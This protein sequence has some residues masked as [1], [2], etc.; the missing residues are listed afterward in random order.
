MVANWKMN[1]SIAE[2]RAFCQEF[3][4]LVNNIR[5]IDMVICPPFTSLQVLKSE[6]ESSIVK[7]GAQNL[8]G[9]ENGAYTGEISASMLTD[10][11]CCYVIIGHS[12]RRRI[13]GEDDGLIN[14]KVKAALSAG[15]IPILC[16]GETL[17][18]REKSIAEEVVEN[19][20]FSCLENISLKEGELVIAYEPVWAIGTGMNASSEDAQEMIKFIRN[21]LCRIFDKSTAES[22]RILYG[23]SVNENNI[24]E[25]MVKKDIDGA[26]IGGASLQPASFAGIVRFGQND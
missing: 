24:E 10:V 2:T 3:M 5:N 14:R 25:L 9:E 12:E 7:L 19:Q 8:F 13:M 26:L 22:I 23:G 17:Q 18:Q 4:P 20:I 11:G 15:L 16:V 1:K 6:L 21:N